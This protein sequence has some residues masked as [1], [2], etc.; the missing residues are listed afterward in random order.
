MPRG[1]PVGSGDQGSEPQPLAGVPECPA[2]FKA[3]SRA[4][5]ERTVA[6]LA[7]SGLITQAE[8]ALLELYCDTWEDYYEAARESKK[9]GKVLT[10]T[11]GGNHQNPWMVI[12]VQAKA[13]L[14][15][16]G[17]ELGL[18]PIIRSRM[19]IKMQPKLAD[20]S[21]ARFFAAREKQA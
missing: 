5:W 7:P 8:F 17:K 13:D 9:E 2:R 3:A 16:I 6:V 18:G 21:K 12:K 14:V 20:D 1:R 10:R 15:R 19:K 4:V 11:R